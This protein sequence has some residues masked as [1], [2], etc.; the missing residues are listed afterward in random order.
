CQYFKGPLQSFTPLAQ[1]DLFAAPED[2]E[3]LALDL[4]FLWQP[5]GL[6]VAGPKYTGCCHDQLLRSVYT[7]MY[8]HHP[9]W[10][11]KGRSINGSRPVSAFLPRRVARTT[12]DPRAGQRP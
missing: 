2:L 6:T 10:Q 9:G 1:H 3:F 12:S 11:F 8:I 7:V 4:K 5:N